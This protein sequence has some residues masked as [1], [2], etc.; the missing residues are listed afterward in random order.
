MEFI[1]GILGVLALAGVL[2]YMGKS[3]MSWGNDD[4]KDK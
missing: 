2:Y 3:G 1:V 4:D